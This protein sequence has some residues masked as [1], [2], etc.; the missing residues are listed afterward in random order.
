MANTTFSKKKTRIVSEV[1]VLLGLIG[2]IVSFAMAEAQSQKLNAQIADYQQKHGDLD[3]FIE[4]EMSFS[5]FV[6]D[7]DDRDV[8]AILNKE[9]HNFVVQQW[10]LTSSM[11]VVLAGSVVLLWFM[12][13][14]IVRSFSANKMLLA[15]SI[16]ET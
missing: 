9:G 14:W 16:S 1:A 6:N 13:E 7:F 15:L 5:K 12:L 11:I 4:G 3:Q 8:Q 2:V 10:V